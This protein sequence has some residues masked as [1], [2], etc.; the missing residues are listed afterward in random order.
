MINKEVVSAIKYVSRMKPEFLLSE[1]RDYIKGDLSTREIFNIIHP[2]LFDMGLKA[3]HEKNDYR[4]IRTEPKK[5]LELNNEEIQRNEV[6]F[7]SPRVP[8]RLERV[9]EQ[10]IEKK[11]FK[12]WED[13]AVLEKIRKAIVSQKED[14][15]KEGKKRKVTYETGYSV[16]GYLAYQ[17][18][19]Y[20]VQFQH[21]LY[22]MAKDGLLKTRMKI[23]DIGTGPG[24]V[25]L[26]I[27]DLMNRLDDCEAMIYSLE[28]YDENIEA[29]NAI[30]T[31][32]AGIKSKAEIEPPIKAD[33]KNIKDVNIPENLDLIVFSNVLNEIRGFGIEQKADIVR[34]LSGHLNDDGNIVIIEPA[35]KL[36]SIEFRKLSIALKNMGMGIYS[37]CSFIWC[38]GCDPKECWS[39]EQKEDIKPTRLM[40]K[41]AE[42]DEPYRYMNTDIKYSYAIIRKDQLTRVKY[43]VPPKAK[44]ARLSKLEQHTGKRINIVASL[45]SGDL[46]DKKYHLYKIC[47]GTAK[48]PVYAILPPH[49]TT[50]E[51]EYIKTA[52]YGE[53]LELYNVLVRYNKENDSYNIMISKPSRVEPVVRP[54]EDEMED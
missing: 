49:N 45:M 48:K 40:S 36:N 51:N 25:P 23:L 22:G 42:C 19:V 53:V 14:Y 12:K 50:P 44:F 10:Y 34:H 28:L 5:P 41:L 43:R 33:I 15:W 18:P 52:A 24:V 2:M 21:I 29:Y 11:T 8:R 27:I 32:Y 13:N 37:P 54:D 17:F 16:L 31:Q 39:F 38:T 6:F 35:D 7:K 4:I 9:I 3:V 26:S 1:I 46:G 30:V 47:D 20:F